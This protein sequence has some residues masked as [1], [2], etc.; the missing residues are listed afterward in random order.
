M[1]PLSRQPQIKSSKQ[2]YRLWFEFY[3]LSLKETDFVENHEKSKD[4]YKPWGD[5][6][7]ILFDPW[8]KEHKHLF[9]VSRVEQITKVV[10]HDNA[11]NVAIPL[12][13]PVSKSIKQLR[14]LIEEQKSQRLEELG[15]QSYGRKSKS[16]SFGQ[17]ELT[18]GVEI[19]GKTLYEIQLMYTIW[20]DMGK[21][22][23]NTEYCTEVVTRLRN[24]PRSNWI[25]Y[26]LSISPIKDRMGNLRYTDDQL[27]QVRRYIKKGIKICESVSKGQFPGRN[28]L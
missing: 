17:Y 13:Q 4:F 25:P 21:P 7:N 2:H 26:L 28:N 12:N 3:K 8:W 18:S 10:N 1:V 27:R 9:G 14:E 23:I 20:V 22:A 24:R 6:S 15:L 19:R 11:L 16:V 5:V